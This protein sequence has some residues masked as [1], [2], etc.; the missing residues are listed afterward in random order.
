MGDCFV[1]LF[2]HY[3]HC[4]TVFDG[5]ADNLKIFSNIFNLFCKMY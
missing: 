2:V 5:G 3:I 1:L 4:T